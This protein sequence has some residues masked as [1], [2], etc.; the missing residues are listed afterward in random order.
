MSRPRSYDRR[1]S[2]RLRRTVII[3]LVAVLAVGI[4]RFAA[5]RADDGDS[6]ES[7]VYSLAHGVEHEEAEEVCERRFPIDYLP[8]DV[9]DRLGLKGGG[10]Y[11]TA[12]WDEY[13]AEC[14][15]DL[16]TN[17]SYAAVGFED[18]LVREVSPVPVPRTEGISGA[19]RARVSMGGARTT[20]I[21]LIRYL[22]TWRVVSDVPAL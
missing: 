6:P 15:N 21:P 11:S 17:K 13:R 2:R 14:I 3:V 4:V 18:A 22:G 8:P 16:K 10:L 9:V 7:A 1:G 20:T 19:A 12:Q 5:S